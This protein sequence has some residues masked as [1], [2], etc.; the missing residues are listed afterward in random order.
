MEDGQ[1]EINV[2]ES[3]IFWIRWKMDISEGLDRE[4]AELTAVVWEKQGL[5]TMESVSGGCTGRDKLKRKS[6]LTSNDNLYTKCSKGDSP[7]LKIVS[8]PFTSDC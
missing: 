2:M 7:T 8:V 1:V 4:T 3:L 5:S 6:T